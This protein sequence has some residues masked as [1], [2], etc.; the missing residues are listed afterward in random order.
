MD[1][2]ERPA[3]PLPEPTP[4]EYAARLRERLA[5][6]DW[7]P[8]DGELVRELAPRLRGSL[9]AWVEGF[10]RHL[11]SFPRTAYFLHD[12]GLIERLKV[13]QRQHFSSLLEAQ[14]DADFVAGRRQVGYTHALEGIEPELFLGAYRMYVQYCLEALSADHP[15]EV[16]AEFERASALFKAIFL[17]IGLTLEAYFTEATHKLHNALSLLWQANNDLRRFA[18]LASHDLK[19]PLATVANLC[20]EVVDE[21]G[22]QIPTLA[23][24]QLESAREV[25]YRLSRLI[26]ELLETTMTSPS[27][28]ALDPVA[29]REALVESVDRLR[30]LLLQ[31]QIE[32]VLP[33]SMPQVWGNKV[34]LREAFYNVLANAAK[35]LDKQPGRIR[36]EVSRNAREAI[37]AISDNGPGIPAEELHR[38]FAPFHRSAAHRD[39]PGTGLGLYFTKSIVEEA[40][41]RVWVESQVGRGS[42]FFLAIPLEAP[43]HHR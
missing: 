26:D 41:G 15:P 19:T 17:D 33:E 37:F 21:F 23:R 29:S 7:Q 25:M 32:L 20:D 22:S 30:P 3:D 42:T 39:R 38:V 8:G 34:R 31:K 18:Q 27:P 36:V 16:Q 13:K 43:R 4:A 10:Y 12:E 14:F 24:T 6:L 11:S 40:G 9:E 35:F 2:L 1:P 28:H 5:F